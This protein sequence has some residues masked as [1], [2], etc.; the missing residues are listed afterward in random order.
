[1]LQ[2]RSNKNKT[3]AF[4]FKLQIEQEHFFDTKDYLAKDGKGSLVH[5]LIHMSSNNPDSQLHNERPGLLAAT[6]AAVLAAGSPQCQGT[7]WTQ[8]QPHRAG[9]RHCQYSLLLACISFQGAERRECCRTI[10][11]G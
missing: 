5:T 2:I 8:E 9:N 11:Q 3:S 1:M 10:L 4:I 6:A 7:W